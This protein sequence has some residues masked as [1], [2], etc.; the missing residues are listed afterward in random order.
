MLYQINK[1]GQYEGI[2]YMEDRS[3]IRTDRA[4]YGD[5]LVWFDDEPD[6]AKRYREQEV[7]KGELHQAVK[8]TFAELK[9]LKLSELSAIAAS[10][11]QNVCKAMV[12]KSSLGFRADADR[13]TRDNIRGLIDLGQAPVPYRTADNESRLL[14]IDNLRTLL[15]EIT[16]N[17]TNLYMQKWQKES[18]IN[19]ATTTDELNA[20][21]LTFTMLSF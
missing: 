16:Q 1:L 14:T 6:F 20:V 10:F 8:L 15:N 19:A 9:A 13:R 4:L 17:G 5:V 11:E 21:D 2:A 7:A 3:A 18:A 12:I